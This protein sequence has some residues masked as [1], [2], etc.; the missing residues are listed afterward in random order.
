MPLFPLQEHW[1]ILNFQ[2]RQ[3]LTVGGFPVTTCRKEGHFKEA[4]VFF[5]KLSEIT[6][7]EALARSDFKV[8][9]DQ[10]YHSG[11]HKSITS[12]FH[13]DKHLSQ[14][15]PSQHRACNTET[16]CVIEKQNLKA[17]TLYLLIKKY[18]FIF[19]RVQVGQG[20]R[21]GDR[22]SKAGSVLTG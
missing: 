13:F 12:T 6:K 7:G 3:S 4:Q 9:S 11:N 1:N 14:A 10:G 16:V 17:R 22:G 21:E 18:V 5:L 20:Q 19:G 2:K 8:Y 15:S